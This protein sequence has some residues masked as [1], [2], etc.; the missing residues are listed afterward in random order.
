MNGASFF[1]PSLVVGICVL[2]MIS[3][4]ALQH[5]QSCNHHKTIFFC[6]VGA[7]LL[8][9]PIH[10]LQVPTQLSDAEYRIQCSAVQY[11]KYSAVIQ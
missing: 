6:V 5:T 4:N 2:A 8:C 7:L 9:I 1:L 11:S 3:W 10:L